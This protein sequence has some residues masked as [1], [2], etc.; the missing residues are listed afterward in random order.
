MKEEMEDR[1]ES[2]LKTELNTTTSDTRLPTHRRKT[3]EK[4][5]NIFDL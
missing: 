1:K 5:I 2:M 4:Y 3:S